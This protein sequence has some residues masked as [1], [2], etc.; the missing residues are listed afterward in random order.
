[1]PAPPV[2]IQEISKETAVMMVEKTT[3]SSPR[4]RASWSEPYPPRRLAPGNPEMHEEAGKAKFT[5]A[6]RNSEKKS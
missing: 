3:P 6:G 4:R 1:M 2:A 5:T